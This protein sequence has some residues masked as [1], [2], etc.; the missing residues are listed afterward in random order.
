[1]SRHERQLAKQ[2]ANWETA[3]KRA[4]CL[5]DKGRVLEVAMPNVVCSKC[6]AKYVL[7]V[8]SGSLFM[9]WKLI[10]QTDVASPPP[11]VTKEVVKEIVK[12][13]CGHCGNLFDE[14]AN[15]CP[16]CGAG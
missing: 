4:R 7:A 8:Q 16:N 15:K 10:P 14:R 5:E 1:M 11:M 2:R 13:R 6:S 3:L 12:I 9:R